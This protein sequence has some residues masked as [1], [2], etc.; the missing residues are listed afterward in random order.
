MNSPYRI[1]FVFYLLVSTLL[2]EK[3]LTISGVKKILKLNNLTIVDLDHKQLE[4]LYL[5]GLL[6]KDLINPLLF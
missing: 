5:Q 6:N 4:F 1:V 2:K 3:G